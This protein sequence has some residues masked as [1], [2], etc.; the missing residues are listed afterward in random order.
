MSKVSGIAQVAQAVGQMDEVTQ[1]N[2]ALVEQAAAAAESLEG[3]AHAL[4]LSVSMFNIGD[5]E[6]PGGQRLEAPLRPCAGYV[7]GGA[8]TAAGAQSA[9]CSL[10]ASQGPRG[11]RARSSVRMTGR[12][13]ERGQPHSAQ[14]S[15]SFRQ[16]VRRDRCRGNRHS[17]ATSPATAA[18]WELRRAALHMGT[19]CDREFVFTGADFERIRK[20]IHEHAGIALS[21]AKRDMVYSRLARRLR[22]TGVQF[23]RISAAPRARPERVGDLR[24]FADYQSHLVLS[25]GAS[26]RD[27]GQAH[28]AR[29]IARPVPHLVRGRLDRRRGVLARHDGM[30]SLRVDDA[31]GGDPRQRYRHHCARAWAKG[32]YSLERIERLTP[33]RVRQFMLKGTASQAGFARV[34]P[35]LQRLV[36]FQRINLLE[37]NWPLR[38]PLDAIFCRNVMIYFD[39]P[40]QYG[41][42]RRFVPLLH[43]DGLM[44]AGH[45][46]SFMHAA[47]LFRSLGRTVHERA[48]ARAG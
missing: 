4:V 38:Q 32:I 21:S 45:S 43:P 36:R 48:D 7:Q 26:L 6:L 3:Q 20:F 11:Q 2:A 41:I 23:R 17:A 13:F 14:T 47:D 27:P 35:E 9:G 5:R 39:K 42:L 34:A 25:R 30:R 1:Q 18:S 15:A 29:Y 10:A 8:A 33:E 28:E 31:A 44:F 12:S 19:P 24:Q 16:R 40:T 37:Q 46:E 22:A